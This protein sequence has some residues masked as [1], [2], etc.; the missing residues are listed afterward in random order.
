[1]EV[2]TTLLANGRVTHV[3]DPDRTGDR[4]YPRHRRRRRRRWSRSS[5]EEQEPVVTLADAQG[6]AAGPSGHRD[7]PFRQHGRRGDRR[8][9]QGHARRRRARHPPARHPPAH[10]AVADGDAR[11]GRQPR[12]AGRTDA[13]HH[14]P[15]PAQYRALDRPGVRR[16]R[17]RGPG[18]RQGCGRFVRAQEHAVA[19]GSRDDRRGNAVRPSAQV[20]R[21]PL[22]EPDRRQPGARAGD[23]AHD[24]LRRRR[25]AAREP[26]RL[27]LRTTAPS[28]RAP[29]P[30][31]RCRC[32]CGRAYKMPQLTASSRAAG[33]PTP[34]G[35][36]A[37][38]GPWAM[39]SLVRETALDVAARKIGIDPIEIRRRNLVYRGRP[40]DDE[41]AR[42]FRSRTSRPANASRNC[43]RAST[44]LPSAASRPRRARPGVISGS[45][46][47]PISSRPGSPAAWR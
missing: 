12:R 1:M 28:R 32:S 43:S 8:G 45:A 18:D 7:Q 5:I 23:D 3:G 29:T 31:S 42:A 40:A 22:R 15:E 27:R 44:S 16:A 30:T 46:S 11:R 36:A 17:T 37:Y 39:E 9:S 38:R 13:L 14:L 4:R 35:S 33:T 6:R 20:D 21:G 19:R 25:P 10:L 47:P 24:R 34:S 41:R 26:R 2:E